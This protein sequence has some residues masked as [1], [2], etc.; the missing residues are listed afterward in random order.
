MNAILLHHGEKR[1]DNVTKQAVSVPKWFDSNMLFRLE[2]RLMGSSIVHCHRFFHGFPIALDILR[3]ITI[4]IESLRPLSILLS[5]AFFANLQAISFEHSML[6]RRLDEDL[7]TPT[8]NSTR[9]LLV[10][11]MVR[12]SKYDLLVVVM[13]SSTFFTNLSIL[14]SSS[15]R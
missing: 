10:Q 6:S 11:Y 15:K 9:S 2:S 5:T 7:C 12:L 3:M 8:K 13:L 1:D 14:S 4:V